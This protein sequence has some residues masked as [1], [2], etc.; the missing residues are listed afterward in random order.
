MAKKKTQLE[1]AIENIE[2]DIAAIRKKAEGE[3]A[4]LELASS[5]LFEQQRAAASK[6]KPKTVG[7]SVR[8]SG[9]SCDAR[10]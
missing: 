8:P 7:A 2:A 4:V 1:R 3:I 9:E 10:R 6:R 5:R